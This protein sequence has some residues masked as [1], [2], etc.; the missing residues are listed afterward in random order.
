MW[1]NGCCETDAMADTH[2]H[3]DWIRPSLLGQPLPATPRVV[4]FGPVFKRMRRARR[5]T[6]EQLALKTGM[7]TAYIRELEH[8][9]MR[10]S[11]ST[12]LT[13]VEGLGV[14]QIVARALVRL[15]GGEG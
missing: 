11:V 5:M 7:A 3:S 10:P 15:A 8:G 2:E 6:R 1:P 9:R 12:L 4:A 13:L 14:S